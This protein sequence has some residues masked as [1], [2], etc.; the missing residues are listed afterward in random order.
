VPVGKV[1]TIPPRGMV[2]L[3][4]KRVKGTPHMTD[5]NKTTLG[6]Q[7]FEFIQQVEIQTQEDRDLL[8]ELI[9]L[10]PEESISF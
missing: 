9:K 3:Y 8:I 5:S 4:I 10:C 2:F 1:S 7:L 6:E